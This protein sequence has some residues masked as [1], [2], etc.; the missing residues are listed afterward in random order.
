MSNTKSSNQS[1]IDSRA[2][3]LI[4][5]RTNQ[6]SQRNARLFAALLA[7]EFVAGIVIAATLSPK[8]WAGLDSRV[9]PHLLTAIVLGLA[10]VAFPIFLAFVSPCAVVTR[11]AIAIGQMLMGGLLIHLT[12][13]RI[14]T[15]FYIFGSL[16]FLSYFGDWKVVV[17]ATVV[18]AGDHFLRG[19]FWPQSIYGIDHAGYLRTLEHAGWVVFEDI[20]LVIACVKAS[21]DLAT[22]CKE[23]AE[24]E[25]TRGILQHQ[26]AERTALNEEMK[27]REISLNR[28]HDQRAI[29]LP[30]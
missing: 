1:A 5:A 8:T 25:H 18:T 14:E 11:H 22:H 20:F 4:A 26:I 10:I 12:A 29:F 9:H 30:I 21:K 24:L 23:E 16:A 17:T 15:H 6:I 19:F 28:P 27:R 7:I 2:A 13:G 3:E